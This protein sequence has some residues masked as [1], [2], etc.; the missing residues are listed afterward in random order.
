MLSDTAQCSTGKRM[1]TLLST[2]IAEFVIAITAATSAVVIGTKLIGDMASLRYR[3]SP[4][5][6]GN[7]SQSYTRTARSLCVMVGAIA[8]AIKLPSIITA[9]GKA[10]ALATGSSQ[11]S[12]SIVNILHATTDPD[13]LTRL[14]QMLE[15]AG[16]ADIAVGYFF[17]SGF[18]EVADDLSQLG[19]VRILV[20]RTD[21]QTLEAVAAGLQQQQALRARLEQAV[22]CSAQS[23]R[24]GRPGDRRR[25]RRRRRGHATGRRVT[26]GR[27]QVERTDCRGIPG[28]PHLSS[29]TSSRQGVSVLV[30]QPRRTRG[31][32]RRLF[33]LHTRRASPATRNSTYG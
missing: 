13:L 2:P 16:R 14:K 8:G 18:S 20:G 30:R 3:L 24:C 22:R 26:A 28:G 21:R 1:A 15:S 9:I 10:I 33:Q 4:D 25:H 5:F 6:E 11:R 23:S 7:W 32:H 31:S 27:Y 17:M 12:S 19:K 29:R